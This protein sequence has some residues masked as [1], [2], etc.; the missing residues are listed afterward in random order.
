MKNI[1]G[2]HFAVFRVDRED[3][4]FFASE[5]EYFEDQSSALN[6]AAVQ[7]DIADFKYVVL[8]QECIKVF[9]K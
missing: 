6:Y 9:S 5:T 4:T 7:K 3:N 1:E 2:L 8:K